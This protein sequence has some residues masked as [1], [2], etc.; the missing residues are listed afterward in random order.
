MTGAARRLGLLRD[1]DYRRLFAATTASHFG[2]Q[3][4]QLAISLVA[5]DHLRATQF[6]AG[7]LVTLMY[8][9]FLI[10]GLPAGAW[11]DRVRRRPVLIASD[12][13]RGAL[14][15]SVPLAWWLGALTMWH[16]YLVA[17]LHGVL[18][19]FFDVAYQSYLPHLI[20]RDR[21]V[22]GNAKLDTTGSVAHIAGPSVA[23]EL[24]HLVTAPVTLA[25]N[26]LAMVASGLLIFAIG[27]RECR[28]LQRRKRHL[29]GEIADGVRFVFGNRLLSA[30]ALS[31]ATYKLFNG[32]YVAVLVFFLRRNLGTAVGTIGMIA[33][34]AAVGSLA[35]A[36][37]A[38]RITRW[39]GQGVAIWASI[40]STTPLL[41]LMP[42]AEPGWRLWLA[43]AGAGVAAIGVSVYTIAQ[44]S[45]R[46]A[47][48]PDHLL[49][50]MNATIRFLAWG[51]LAVGGLLGSTLGARFGT[52]TTL[53]FGA[54]GM[55]TAFLPVL[56]SP[57]RTI[58]VPTTPRDADFDQSPR[59]HH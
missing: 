25:L 28:P 18:N 33:S 7:L 42:L 52:R 51:A 49:G 32:V 14:L 57:L 37:V 22:E 23:G 4:T 19:V 3:I 27:K 15:L 31:S 13:G 20:G 29:A 26:A 36:V 10:I 43:A 58:R 6:Q 59:V 35:G 45:L 2:I 12:L 24:I 17:F 55:C 38:H 5:I 9:A 16:L 1:R 50:R 56:L 46:Q 53:M 40:G 39:L 48:T 11:L 30:V 54:A 34:I 8:S 41:L 44:V 47:L 21:L